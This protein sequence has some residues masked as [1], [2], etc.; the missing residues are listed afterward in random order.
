MRFMFDHTY[1]VVDMC[2]FIKTDWNS[3]YGDV[4]ELLLSDAHVPRVNEVEVRLFVDSDHAG[5]HFTWCS[6][7]YLLST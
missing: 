5:E 4:K 3:M 6:R 2:A 7:V 1:H